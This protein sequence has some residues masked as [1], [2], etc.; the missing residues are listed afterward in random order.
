[1]KKIG[2]GWQYTVYDLDNGRVLKKFHSPLWSY[3]TILKTIFPFNN[4]S[5]TSIPR[6]S[7]EMKKKAL[8]SFDILRKAKIPTEWL[9]QPSFVNKLDFEQDKVRPLHDVFSIVTIE[10]SKQII[11]KF[12]LFNKQLL[13]RG[14]IDKSFNVTK[15]YGLDEKGEIVLIDIGEL[16]VGEERI[17]QQCLDRTWAKDYVAGCIENEEVREYFIQ[18]MDFNFLSHLK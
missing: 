9:G 12:I 16:F 4:D 17:R 13:E 11:D 10:E 18:Q 2:E 7:R 5:L 6:Y 14:L 8:D 1:M 15:N 3:W